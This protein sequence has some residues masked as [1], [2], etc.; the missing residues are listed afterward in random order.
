MKLNS[1][2]PYSLSHTIVVGHCFAMLNKSMYNKDKSKLEQAQ[3]K[4]QH[5]K[6]GKHLNYNVV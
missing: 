3:D 1:P 5:I 4:L 2:L 6:T